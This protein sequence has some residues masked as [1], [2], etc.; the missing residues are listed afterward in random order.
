MTNV[1]N[2]KAKPNIT[3]VIVPTPRRIGKARVPTKL[4]IAKPMMD[5][6]GPRRN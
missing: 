6:T 4:E 3:R 5:A 1:T 2:S